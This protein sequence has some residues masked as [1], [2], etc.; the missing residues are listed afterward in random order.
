[1]TPPIGAI[2][3][4]STGFV[5]VQVKLVEQVLA[6]IGTMQAEAEM[7]PVVFAAHLVP[8][9]LVPLAQVALAGALS[10]VPVPFPPV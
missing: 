1:M 5:I 9:H 10:S 6:F 2:K 7:V 8:F 3:E 4:G